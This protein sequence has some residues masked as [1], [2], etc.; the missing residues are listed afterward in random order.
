MSK[1]LIELLKAGFWA[2]GQPFWEL[3]CR[4]FAWSNFSVHCHVGGILDP[5]DLLGLFSGNLFGE[6]VEEGPSQAVGFVLELNN[7]PF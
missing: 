6:T 2:I 5:F 7:P 4:P 1:K 3:M